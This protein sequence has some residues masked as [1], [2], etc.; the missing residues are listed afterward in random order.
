MY[1][2][3]ISLVDYIIMLHSNVTMNLN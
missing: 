1:Y 3:W 2:Y